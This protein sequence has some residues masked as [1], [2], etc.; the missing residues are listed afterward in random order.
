[1]QDDKGAYKKQVIDEVCNNVKN[2]KMIAM[3]SLKS[4]KIVDENEQH[5]GTHL[6]P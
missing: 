4:A 2:Y 1:M 5:G 3:P 6:K